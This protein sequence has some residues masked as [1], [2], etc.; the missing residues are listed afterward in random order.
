MRFS[1]MLATINPTKENRF[2]LKIIATLCYNNL[3]VIFADQN[4]DD[5]LDSILAQYRSLFPMVGQDTGCASFWTPAR[6]AD[7]PISESSLA[8]SNR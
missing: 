5:Q 6:L 2:L 3:E 4:D 7:A 1:I 8:V